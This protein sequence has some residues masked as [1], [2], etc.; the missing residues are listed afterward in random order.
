[1][2]EEGINQTEKIRRNASLNSGPVQEFIRH[3]QELH[4]FGNHTRA[5]KVNETGRQVGVGGLRFNGKA[6]DWPIKNKFKFWYSKRR[7]DGLLLLVGP[8]DMVG[9]NV[10]WE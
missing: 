8:W 10:G 7:R 6:G 5:G 2:G 1:L 3:L 9:S 4:I